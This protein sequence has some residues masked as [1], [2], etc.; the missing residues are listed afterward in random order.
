[1]SNAPTTFSEQMNFENAFNGYNK[2][3]VEAFIAYID[4]AWVSRNKEVTDLR[5]ENAQLKVNLQAYSSG[6]SD[7]KALQEQAAKATEA[8]TRLSTV[9]QNSIKTIQEKDAEIAALKEKLAAKETARGILDASSDEGVLRAQI[10][11]Q[12]MEIEKLENSTDEHLKVRIA[13]LEGLLEEVKKAHDGNLWATLGNS[14]QIIEDS[15]TK[16]AEI[17]MKDAQNKAKGIVETAKHNSA[18]LLMRAANQYDALMKAGNEQQD[19]ANEK[20]GSGFTEY[21]E[22]VNSVLSAVNEMHSQLEDGYSKAMEMLKSIEEKTKPVEVL[23]DE[24]YTPISIGGIQKAEDMQSYRE[25]SLAVDALS[26]ESAKKYDVPDLEPTAIKNTQDTPEDSDS[27]DKSSIVEDAGKS[28]ATDDGL[29]ALVNT[30]QEQ[31]IPSDDDDDNTGVIQ[32]V[33]EE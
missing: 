3:Q 15:A 25:T 29:A 6:E 12:K 19:V 21:K 9:N 33:S 8:I 7:V 23:Q 28:D 2:G 30:T 5:N 13:E 24:A 20:L 26:V 14:A 10:E 18:E 31:G 17:I 22:Y 11:S 4:K 1:M 32:V 27:D 16:R